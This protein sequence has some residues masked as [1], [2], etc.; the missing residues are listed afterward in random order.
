MEEE[1]IVFRLPKT[2][3]NDSKD[4]KVK[5]LEKLEAKQIEYSRHMKMIESS[6]SS[7]S[8][9]CYHCGLA[10]SCE[11][12]IS[13][14]TSE[15]VQI[16]QLENDGRKRKMSEGKINPQN[17]LEF[18]LNIRKNMPDSLL[19]SSVKSEEIEYYTGAPSTLSNRDMLNHLISVRVEYV[20]RLMRPLVHKLMTHQKNG[21]AFNNPV[22][23]VSLGLKDY[24]S[25][26]KRPMDLGTVKCKLLRGEYHTTRECA[27]DVNLVFR[28]AIA[29]NPSSHI[30][31][32]CAILLMDEFKEELKAM[33]EKLQKDVSSFSSTYTFNVIILF[34]G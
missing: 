34:L 2:L 5:S 14:E 12:C 8:L 24:N 23:F 30:V 25:K 26:V 13:H 22:D 32:Q 21:D 15:D 11:K 3:W 31:H 4:S 27:E 1:R 33:K 28:N 7:G 18:L 29:Y 9:G 20:Q 6:M 16:C 17:V 19:L 10:R